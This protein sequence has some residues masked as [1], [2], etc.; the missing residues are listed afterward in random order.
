[1]SLKT[2]ISNF[3]ERVYVSDPP[4]DA[5]YHLHIKSLEKFDEEARAEER[6]KHL[7]AFQKIQKE[8][9]TKD[10]PGCDSLAVIYDICREAIAPQES[11]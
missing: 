8:A 4:K 6:K 1:M 5:W 11:K 2:R 3:L 7:R 10:K 9:K